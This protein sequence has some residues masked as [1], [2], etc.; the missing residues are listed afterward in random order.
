[1]KTTMPFK[2]L[3]WIDDNREHLKPPVCNKQMFESGDFIVQVVGGPNSRTDYHL[4]EGPELFYQVEGQM[5]LKTVQDGEFVD[6]P[7]GEGEIFLLPP[8]VPHSPQRLPKSVGI[9]V[10][11][12]RAPHELD[13]FMWFCPNCANKLHEE[14]LHV[15]DIVKDLPPVFERF[16]GNVEART[17]K[18]CGTVMPP[19]IVVA[20]PKFLP[21]SAGARALDAAD[22]LAALRREFELPREGGRTLTYLCGHSLGLMPRAARRS[23]GAELERWATLGVDGHFPDARPPRGPRRAPCAP[24]TAAGST[25]T[26]SSRRCS[27]I[28]WA[29]IATRSSR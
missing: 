17:C 11:R 23:V 20:T 16:Y 21:G 9:V 25:I 4:D 2:L 8:R 5:V 1:M 13:G 18:R 15:A 14:Y 6:I 12:A 24:R 28:S 7:I 19:K 26:R 27:P 10:E 29:R 22:E 3:D